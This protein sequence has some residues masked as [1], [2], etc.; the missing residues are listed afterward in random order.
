MLRK[1]PAAARPSGALIAAIASLVG[2]FASAA[3]LSAMS[4]TLGGCA[5]PRVADGF[6]SVTPGMSRD[7]V[8]A[9]LGEPSS[10]WAL[11]EARDGLDGERLQWG[12][13]LSSLASGAAF[14]GA[15]ERAWS[16][17]FGADG[18]VIEAVAPR[19]TDDAK[20]EEDELRAR[21]ARRDEADRMGE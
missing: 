6:A 16:V 5:P 1:N 2:P 3:I 8:V 7:E 19:W 4:T 20:A 12:D 11:V 15:P 9:I 10:R 18:R 17:V 13:S 14:R 21:R